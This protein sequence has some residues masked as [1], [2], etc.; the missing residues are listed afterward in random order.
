MLPEVLNFLESFVIDDKKLCCFSQ[1]CANL[2]GPR[3]KNVL[4]NSQVEVLIIVFRAS[5][6]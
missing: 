3:S 5:N 4:A 1:T 6:E 2:L